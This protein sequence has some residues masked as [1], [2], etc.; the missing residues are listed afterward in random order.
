MTIDVNMQL[1]HMITEDLGTAGIESAIID[2]FLQRKLKS[3]RQLLKL[4]FWIC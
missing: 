1:S 2:V 4:R 3:M